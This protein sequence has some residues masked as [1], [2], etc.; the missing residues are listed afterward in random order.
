MITL[1]V[2]EEKPIGMVAEDVVEVTTSD[3]EKLI[4]HPS[5]N[6]T[7]LIGNYDEIDPTVPEW[8][9]NQTEE[10]QEMGE[11]HIEFLWES[12]FK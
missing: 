4:N 12:I 9:K 1:T 8:V 5:I 3:Y 10:P 2:E 11:T 6:G 7:K